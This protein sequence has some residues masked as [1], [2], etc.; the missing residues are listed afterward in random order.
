M[1]MIGALRIL[2][3]VLVYM[4]NWCLLLRKKMYISIEN[5][6]KVTTVG[7]YPKKAVTRA[8]VCGWAI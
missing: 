6:K 7:M 5:V 1:N 3:L 8:L 2:A 4:K